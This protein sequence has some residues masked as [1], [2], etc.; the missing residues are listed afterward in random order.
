MVKNK[1]QTNKGEMDFLVMILIFLVAL[2]VIWVLTG[3]QNDADKNKPFI[4]PGN[5][6]AEPLHPYGPAN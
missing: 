3:G 4:T 5:D 1:L 2:F 6:T